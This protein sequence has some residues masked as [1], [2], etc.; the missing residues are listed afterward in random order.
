MGRRRK[1]Y[2]LDMDRSHD[3]PL[4]V[5]QRWQDSGGIWRVVR[6][7]EI[8]LD[9]ELV[10]CTGDEVMGRLSSGDPAVLAFVGDRDSSEA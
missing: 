8:G 4:A 1:G 3:E 2:P 10:T 6:R 9:I 7:T 5:L